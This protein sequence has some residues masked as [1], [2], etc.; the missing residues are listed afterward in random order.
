MRSRWRGAFAS[1]A[2]FVAFVP[3]VARGQSDTERPAVWGQAGVGPSTANLGGLVAAS[4]VK[5]PHLV[6][7]RAS[8]VAEH[9]DGGEDEAFD[10]AVL[11]GRQLRRHGAFRPA[12]AAGLAY[13]KCEG[14]DDG[15]SASTVGLALSVEAALWPTSAAGIGLHGFGNVNSVASFAGVAVTIHLGRLR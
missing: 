7:A 11:Y 6:S 10:V 5:G 4:A 14:C 15:R 9:L 8:F 1:L 2:L 12:A 13:V 3:R